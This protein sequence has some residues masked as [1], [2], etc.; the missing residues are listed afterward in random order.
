MITC[1]EHIL[2]RIFSGHASNTYHNWYI[3]D[4]Y[5]AILLLLTGLKDIV[6]VII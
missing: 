6:I 1:P 4:I 3:F 5:E 2:D